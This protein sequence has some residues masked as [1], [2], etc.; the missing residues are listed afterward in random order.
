[1]FD[2]DR[3]Y[4]ELKQSLSGLHE[5]KL[6]HVRGLAEHTAPFKYAYQ[7]ETSTKIE[8]KLKPAHE[9]WREHK[10]RKVISKLVF[11]PE[12]TYQDESIFNLWAG[13]PMKENDV[14]GEP[15]LTLEM[16]F[17]SL[18]NRDERKFNWLLDWLAHIIQCPYKKP[19]VVPILLGE[20]GT[21][22]GIL[23]EKIMAKI[24]GPLF[25][26]VKSSHELTGNFN[27]HLAMKLLINVDEA[28]WRGNKTED[29][30]LKNLIGS[31]NLSVEEKFKGRYT[32]DDFARFIITSNNDEAVAIEMGNR[33]YCVIETGKEWAK[34]T[35]KYQP[36]LNAIEYDAEAEKFFNFLKA[37]DISRFN[38]FDIL[39]NNTAGLVSKIA[40]EGVVSEFW[41]D[42]L[43]ENPRPILNN[44]GLSRAKTYDCFRAFVKEVSTYEKSLTPKNFWSRT[45][46]IFPYL[47][48]D[49]A[50]RV[51]DY[52]GKRDRTHLVKN[53]SQLR[54]DYSSKTQIENRKINFEDSEYCQN[55]EFQPISS[56]KDFLL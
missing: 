13:F 19:S 25:T 14:E 26:Q 20:Q 47:T 32:I 23:N 37:R 22:K 2:G 35:E 42:V 28:T 18:C 56:T 53:I 39:E 50:D 12:K 1:M 4:C 44:T 49:K 55:G 48:Q 30:I 43:F 36:L 10:N 6:Y 27:S 46:K 38:P 9:I 16:I 45:T 29:G 5:V 51:G 8:E 40:S 11:H 21:G 24:L 3:Q 52:N 41:F 17:V 15:S 34:K 33:R 54:K 7:K 31:A